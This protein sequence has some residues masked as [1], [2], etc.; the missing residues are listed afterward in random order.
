VKVDLPVG[1]NLQDHPIVPIKFL[2]SDPSAMF[3]PTTDLNES[4]VDDFFLRG[5]VMYLY[6]FYGYYLA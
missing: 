5:Q 1:Q 4:T 6:A 2:I 3:D